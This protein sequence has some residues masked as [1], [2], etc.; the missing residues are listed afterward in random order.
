ML[1][2]CMS[3]MQGTAGSL[4][5]DASVFSSH[6]GTHVSRRPLRVQA[7]M[8]P[9]AAQA[10]TSVQERGPVEPAVPRVPKIQ[11]GVAAYVATGTRSL[12][13]QV[14]NALPFWKAPSNLSNSGQE[15]IDGDFVREVA[16][17]AAQVEKKAKRASKKEPADIRRFLKR[18]G[19]SEIKHIGLMSALSAHSYLVP[20]LTAERLY[21]KFRLHLVTTSVACERMRAP[22][23]ATAAEAMG[24]GDGMAMSLRDIQELHR[25]MYGDEEEVEP[26][27]E[28]KKEKGVSP[29]DLVA[30]SLAAAAAVASQAAS[31]P[32]QV[33]G[34]Q[35][36]NAAAAGH[37]T[38]AA[39]VATVT[40]AVQ[41]SLGGQ[42]KSKKVPAKGAEACSNPTSWFVADDPVCG[43]RYF[44][45]QGSDNFDHWK[46]NLT[47]D[48]VTFE[49][50][51]LGVKVHRGIY[52]AAQIL[53]NR[54]LPMVV[55]HVQLHPFAKIAFTGHSLGG[56]LGTMLM[57]M[58]IRRGVVPPTA[59]DPTY[60]FGAP[61]IFCE[62]GSGCGPCA[63][64][65]SLEEDNDTCPGDVDAKAGNSLLRRAGAA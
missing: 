15:V 35:L 36:Q 18:T 30:S 26:K 58:Y 62:G 33:V 16:K 31:L 11:E 44:V 20:D 59:F 43:I 37:S 4:V 29:G 45:I 39:T 7:V 57:L 2:S 12:A 28:I 54:F 51:D 60:T 61:A 5:R 65:N 49:D 25:R 27:I 53:Y 1:P 9:A 13:G 55:E 14:W 56:S 34:S 50:P 24:E 41:S 10:V 22:Q 40:A 23:V 48:P 38:A 17:Q 52:E 46:M 6:T 64:G 8:M 63:G 47:F 3:A 19:L 32:M 42:D 21:R